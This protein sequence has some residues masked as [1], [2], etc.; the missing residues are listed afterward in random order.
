MPV[1]KQQLFVPGKKNYKTAKF[2][3]LDPLVFLMRRFED[4]LLL[5]QRKISLTV[6]LRYVF[7]QNKEQKA[8]LK[9][10]TASSICPA[11][12]RQ[13]AAVYVRRK[14]SAKANAAAASKV[15]RLRSAVWSALLRTGIMNMWPQHR[16]NRSLTVIRLLLSAPAR[17]VWPA[18]ATWQNSAMMSPCLKHC[19]W[20]AVYWY[21]VSRNSVCRNPSSAKKSIT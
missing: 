3:P 14:A 8:N 21:T 9:K 6:K 16:R 2:L 5:K 20:Q 11:P 1:L 17:P 19:T 4:N 10:H 12:F 7:R 18:Q 13:S 15:S